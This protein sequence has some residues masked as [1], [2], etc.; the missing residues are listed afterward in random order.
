MID[1]SKMSLAEVRALQEQLA[2]E[3]KKREQ[4]E[5][6]QARAQI[7]AIAKSVGLPLKDLLKDNKEDRT[8]MANVRTKGAVQYRH[9]ANTALQWSGRGRKPQWVKEWLIAGNS[10]DALRV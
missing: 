3:V 5:I 10:L 8:K 1:L 4:E 2:Q 7:E 9:P 6:A